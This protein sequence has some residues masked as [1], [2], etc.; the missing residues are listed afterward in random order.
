MMLPMVSSKSENFKRYAHF[1][2]Q[3]S[4]TASR[5]G[6]D[7][8]MVR[9]SI[10]SRF[11]IDQTQNKTFRNHKNALQHLYTSTHEQTKILEMKT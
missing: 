3:I 4:I 2:E 6:A 5:L 8:T 7:K 11:R 1:P 10:S 9:I